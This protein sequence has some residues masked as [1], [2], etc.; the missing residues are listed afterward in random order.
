MPNRMPRQGDL[1]AYFG[2]GRSSTD[3]RPAA[4][5]HF[6]VNQYRDARAGQDTTPLHAAFRLDGKIIGAVSREG[7]VS[8]AIRLDAALTAGDNAISQQL[9]GIELA[10]FMTQEIEAEL[11]TLF[12]NRVE[13]FRATEGLMMT[14]GEVNRACRKFWS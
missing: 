10:E 4:R 9:S 11:S 5:D 7:W 14:E 12:G 3:D 2:R 8:I 1:S 13:T 6:A